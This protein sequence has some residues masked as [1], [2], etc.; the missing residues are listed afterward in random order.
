MEVN[1]GYDIYL[2]TDNV[3]L[4]GLQLY[5]SYNTGHLNIIY[6]TDGNG[7]T[8]NLQISNNIIRGSGVFS[9]GNNKTGIGVIGNDPAAGSRVSIWNNIIYGLDGTNIGI[10]RGIYITKPTR[11]A[12]LYNNTIY[13]TDDEGIYAASGVT[14]AK[15]NLLQGSDGNAYGGTFTTS[16]YNLSDDATNTG[17]AHDKVSQTVIF[18]DA[19][20]G[21]FHLAITD[22]A[23]RNAGTST[24][25]IPPP[26]QGGAGGGLDRDIDGHARPAGAAFDIGADEG[27]ISVYYSVGQNTT[28]HKSGTPTLDITSGVATFSVAQTATNLGIGDKVTYN[29]TSVAYLA[30]K[31]STT[32]WRLITATGA[33]PADVAGATVNSIAHAFASLSAAEAGATGASYLNTTDL[34]TNN[35]QLNIPCY[36]DSGPDTTAVTVDGYTTGVPNYIRIYTPYDTTGEVNTSQRHDGVWSD[37]KYRLEP[38]GTVLSVNEPHIIIEGL[39]IY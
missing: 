35:Y 26:F 32:Q 13:D 21:N 19:A 28:D 7:T 5:N 18:D 3:W 25:T 4:D 15:N 1:S 24:I 12:Y 20:N 38:V 9:D 30:Q 37:S 27:S 8:Q 33:M 11:T 31:I 39:Q 22:T 17:G 36:Y 14:I 29:T 10:G 2:N 16:D 6:L 23:A 34:W